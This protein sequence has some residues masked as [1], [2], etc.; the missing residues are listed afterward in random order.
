MPYAEMTALK[1]KI[2]ANAEVRKDALDYNEELPSHQKKSSENIKK[3][4][5]PKMAFHTDEIDGHKHGATD[6]GNVETSVDEEVVSVEAG[7]K[8]KKS[9][10]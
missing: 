9:K 10:Y 5:P 8:K 1:H 7:L 4:Y 6:K 3:K 2:D